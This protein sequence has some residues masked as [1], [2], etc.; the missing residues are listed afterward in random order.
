MFVDDW[1]ISDLI[2]QPA[3]GSLMRAVQ[4]DALGKFRPSRRDAE[5]YSVQITC[6]GAWGRVRVFDGKGRKLFNMDSAFPGSFWLSAGAESG[7]IVSLE[8]DTMAPT[9]T[10]N[11]REQ[12][13][14]LI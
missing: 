14:K 13:A 3:P 9:V 4:L 11:F 1:E 8:S 5:L 10:V 12:D 6:A 2:V 7:I